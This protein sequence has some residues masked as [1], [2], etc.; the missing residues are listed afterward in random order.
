MRDKQLY[1]KFDGVNSLADVYLN[2]ELLT[3]HKGG[4]SAFTVDITDK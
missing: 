1:L 3:T 2:G 4:Y